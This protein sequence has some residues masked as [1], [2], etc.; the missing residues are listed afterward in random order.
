MRPRRSFRPRLSEIALEPR[1]TLSQVP[2]AHVSV[3]PRAATGH[4]LKCSFSGRSDTVMSVSGAGGITTSLR[5]SGR[6]RLLGAPGVSVSGTL[7]EDSSGLQG[8]LFLA[9]RKGSLVLLVTGPQTN[10]TP[11]RPTM[12]DLTFTVIGESG[13]YVGL[14]GSGTLTLR[15][16]MIGRTRNG[17][18]PG[19]FGIK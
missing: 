10:L 13:A 8:T 1:V 17:I 7:T 12:T 9:G 11:K 6:G 5:L 2:M 4:W 18:T 15:F 14:S 3:L 16:Q 19:A